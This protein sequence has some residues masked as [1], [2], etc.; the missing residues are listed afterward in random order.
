MA[1]VSLLAVNLAVL[2]LGLTPWLFHPTNERQ[3]IPDGFPIAS[4]A[5]RFPATSAFTSAA[6]QLRPVTQEAPYAD[7][8]CLACH[9]KR[10]FR[11]HFSDGRRLSLYVNARGL[12]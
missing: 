11:T 7:S 3:P 4:P 8:Y 1:R 5:S 2:G 12:R 9:G 6:D 10:S